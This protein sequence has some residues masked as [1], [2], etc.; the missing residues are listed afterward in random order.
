M[1][2]YRG[3]LARYLHDNYNG[4][5]VDGS[6]GSHPALYF[7][8]NMEMAVKYGYTMYER[9]NGDKPVRPILIAVEAPESRVFHIHET[10][11]EAQKVI[12][13]AW[14][15]KEQVFL[16]QTVGDKYTVPFLRPE[17]VES[18]RILERRAESVEEAMDSSSIPING[19]KNRFEQTIKN[20]AE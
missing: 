5:I 12:E 9:Q 18:I 8:D 19:D 13:N 3:T 1:K 16:Q 4:E 15:G 6:N 7:S 11:K 14:E 10:D 2:L 17:F 20:I